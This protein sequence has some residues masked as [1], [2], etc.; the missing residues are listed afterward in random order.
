MINYFYIINYK[1]SFVDQV[2]L[3]TNLVYHDLVKK[4]LN[5]LFVQVI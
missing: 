4:L 3:H 2:H 5:N 1:N